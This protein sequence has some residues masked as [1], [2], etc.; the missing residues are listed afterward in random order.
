MA[1]M[2]SDLALHKWL[3]S[4]DHSLGELKEEDYHEI[5]GFLLKDYD[6]TYTKA[7]HFICKIEDVEAFR[8][9][10][11]KMLPQKNTVSLKP[12][13]TFG[14][15]FLEDDSSKLPNP[16]INLALTYKGLTQL[17]KK[18]KIKHYV[19]EQFPQYVE[20]GRKRAVSE[21]GD[22]PEEP[23]TGEQTLPSWDHTFCGGNSS[24]A[25]LILTVY[26]KPNGGKNKV[27]FEFGEQTFEFTIVGCSRTEKYETGLNILGEPIETEVLPGG[28]EHFGFRDGIS[29]P[30]IN[31]GPEPAFARRDERIPPW[32]LLIRER[33]EAIYYLPKSGYRRKLFENGSFAAFRILEQHAAEFRDYL[34]QAASL[35]GHT[36]EWLAARMVGRWQNGSP[37]ALFPEKPSEDYYLLDKYPSGKHVLPEHERSMDNVSETINDFEYKSSGLN[38]PF[39]AHIRR[40]NP[41][42][43]IIAGRA[44]LRRINRRLRPYGPEFNPFEPVSKQQRRGLAGYFICTRLKEQFEHL[45]KV[46][47]NSGR[48]TGLSIKEKDPIV[49][50]NPSKGATR[51]EEKGIFTIPKED[52]DMTIKGIPRFVTP[53][54]CLYVFFPSKT[55]L[56][57]LSR[58]SREPT[59][60]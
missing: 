48:F 49:G 46:W 24:D 34:G 3:E 43:T 31:G 57:L 37:L 9:F 21:L 39:G 45:H 36:R 7:S 33:Y 53:Q 15:I 5:Q 29:Q 32:T 11:Q 51:Q 19:K 2:E 50:N 55:A 44:D 1:N 10:L 26:C 47:M 17:I 4:I 40:N 8:V 16:I 6:L 35:T 28:K 27:T 25:H 14:D 56:N 22:L 58:N 41:R 30:W 38:C 42:N 23:R 60:V 20:G 54:G 13:I 18:E 12:M 52:R 59:S